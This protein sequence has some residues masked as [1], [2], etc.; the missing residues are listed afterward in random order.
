MA[1]KQSKTNKKDNSVFE[2]SVKPYYYNTDKCFIY[3]SSSKVLSSQSK[4]S[5][6]TPEKI[7]NKFGFEFLCNDLLKSVRD[8]ESFRSEK[9]IKTL[10]P[11]NI[12]KEIYSYGIETNTMDL[13]V[14]HK[15]SSKIGL[16]ISTYAALKKGMVIVEYVGERKDAHIKIEDTSYL[17][18]NDDGTTYRCKRLRQCC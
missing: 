4:F 14:L 18:I 2:K 9:N 17:L 12:A 10:F 1:K 11:K 13:F 3:Y 5:V 8:A 7:K 15:I 6:L 16:T